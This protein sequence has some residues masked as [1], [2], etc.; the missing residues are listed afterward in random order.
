MSDLKDTTVIGGLFNGIEVSFKVGDCQ[1]TNG[2]IKVHNMQNT[3]DQRISEILPRT[4]SLDDGRLALHEISK[5]QIRGYFNTGRSVPLGIETQ[6]DFRK[7][8]RTVKM[9]PGRRV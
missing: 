7:K 5:K 8:E 1:R 2:C 9:N 4:I 3:D 6:T